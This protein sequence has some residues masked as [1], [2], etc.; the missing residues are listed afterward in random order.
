MK[1]YGKIFSEYMFIQKFRESSKF[2]KKI[3]IEN[4]EELEKIKSKKN[5]VIFISGHFNFELMAMHLEKSDIE[6]AAV[7]D[8]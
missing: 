4:H 6:L 8:L 3:I 5:P 1:N 2:S 7:Y